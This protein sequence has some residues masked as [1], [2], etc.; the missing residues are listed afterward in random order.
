[1]SLKGKVKAAA[2][3]VK[4]KIDK[5]HYAK[6]VA[7]AEKV[8]AEWKKQIADTSAEVDQIKKNAAVATNTAD[9][10]YKLVAN[11]SPADGDKKKLETDLKILENAVKTNLERLT[12]VVKRLE[13]SALA[14]TRNPIQHMVKK[15]V[16]S[17]LKDEAKETVSAVTTA[18]IKP[19][20]FKIQEVQ[21]RRTQISL[22]LKNAGKKG[23][24]AADLL[25]DSS[26]RTAKMTALLLGQLASLKSF[27][28]TANINIKDMSAVVDNMKQR[29]YSA[30]DNQAAVRRMMEDQYKNAST[31]IANAQKTVGTIDKAY[32]KLKKTIPK[33]L[34]GDKKVTA[35]LAGMNSHISKTRDE[36]FRKMRA[37]EQLKDAMRA[38]K[39]LRNLGVKMA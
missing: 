21:K 39:D 11:G 2:G 22:D 3:A 15:K 38:R 27:I 12:S 6:Q 25:K 7:A 5:K 18:S 37:A 26:N 4:D 16:I 9:N 31:L 24:T 29:D 8:I 35:A 34:E 23:E 14:E 32:E 36:I 30:S 10:I 1:M 13:D 28:T 19:L 33:Q 17:S 20:G